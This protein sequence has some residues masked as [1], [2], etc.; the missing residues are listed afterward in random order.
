MCRTVRGQSRVFPLAQ[1]ILAPRCLHR[2]NEIV[3]L[4]VSVSKDQQIF[5]LQIAVDNVLAVNILQ[6]EDYTL[7]RMNRTAGSPAK[8]KGKCRLLLLM[9]VKT[10]PPKSHSIKML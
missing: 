5:W 1:A 7:P 6:S 10:S 8:R 9:K 4:Y 3:Q 2:K